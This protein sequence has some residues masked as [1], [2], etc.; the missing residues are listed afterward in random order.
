M[1]ASFQ[2]LDEQDLQRHASL[3][4]FLVKPGDT[5]ALHGDLGAGKTTFARALITALMGGAAQEI[6][7]PTFTILQT[8][9]TPRLPVAHVDLYRVTDESELDELGLFETIANGLALVEWPERA[10]GR[11][12]T[13]RLDLSIED[14]GETALHCT[15]EI[16]LRNVSLEGGSSWAARIDRLTAM[17]KLFAATGLSGGDCRL[18]YLQGDASARRY[19]RMICRNGRTAIL[20]DWPR[21]PDGPPIR[22]GRPYSRIAHLA[23]HVGPFIALSAALDAHGFTVPRVLAHDRD[24]GLLVLDDLGDGVFGS[25]VQS[26]AIR[27]EMLWQEA[28]DALVAL[29]RFNVAQDLPLPDGT[30]YRLPP[31]DRDALVIETELLL[32]W[33]WPA[34]HAGTAPADVR[35]SFGEVWSAIFDRLLALPKGLALRDFHS[36]N[37][38][39][40]PRRHGIGRVGII[41]FQDALAGHA[42]YDLVSLLQDA[43]LEVEPGL[44]DHLYRRYLRAVHAA[45]PGFKDDEFAF[46][47]A[48]LGAQRA[49]K[50]LGIFSRLAARDG[51]PQ[52]LQHMPR[53]WGYLERNLQSPHLLALRAWYDRFIPP[54][55]RRRPH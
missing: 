12:P 45:E 13:D 38:M 43:R 50:I 5:I 35:A 25:L 48:A 42:A 11:L 3:I 15:G 46:A 18:R 20:M 4:A 22:D 31:Y 28:V 17:S 10:G 1:R 53:I 47:Y 54:A 14:A 40:C 55:A 8:Y 33:Y 34:A 7:S 6:P 29:R 19:G 51:K 9:D 24:R 32:D 52:Y 2:A 49:T 23:E 36:P 41:D 27:Q 39:W 37:L 16:G 30:S 44:E 26:G 21:Q